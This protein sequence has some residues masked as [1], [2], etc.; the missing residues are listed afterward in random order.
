MK[1]RVARNTMGERSGTRD[2]ARNWPEKK[3]NGSS[4]MMWSLLR[5]VTKKTALISH[6]K[7]V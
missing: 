6:Q 2:N 3:A 5:S 7:K 4:H 1:T